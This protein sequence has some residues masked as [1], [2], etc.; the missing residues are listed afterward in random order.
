MV[1]IYDESLEK[2]R[3]AVLGLDKEGRQR[4][5]LLLKTLL[6]PAP[7]DQFDKLTQELRE[8]KFGGGFACPH[9]R[10]L[11]VILN[12]RVRGKQRYLC[13]DCSR[14]FG[15]HSD[16]PLRGTHLPE[17]WLPFM[18]CMIQG[19][20]L[21]RCE[22]VLEV[23]WVTLFYWRHKILAAIKRLEPAAFDGILEVDETYFLESQKGNKN[24]SRKPRKRGGAASKRGIS[25]EQV[26]VV[27][28]R[29]RDKST[30]ARVACHGPIDKAQAKALLDAAVAEVTTLCSDANGTWRSFAA[31]KSLPH[32]ELNGQKNER[33]KRGIFHIQNVNAFHRRLKGWMERFNGVATKYLDHYLA[34]FHFIERRTFV[35]LPSKMR[36]LLIGAC[37][38]GVHSTCRAL[39]Q[40][41]L[42]LPAAT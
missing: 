11:K 40:S 13:R 38:P 20:S 26:C 39:R 34:W 15:D 1:S 36:E 24:L 37:L 27:V 3:A 2:V 10:S 33:V 4:I 16:T 28:A 6:Y 30:L 9:C 23:T 32:I 22:E 42:V 17:K 35:A 5:F 41:R 8:K 21:R 7:A 18:E 25:K 19:L 14:T 12:G 29:D 31:E